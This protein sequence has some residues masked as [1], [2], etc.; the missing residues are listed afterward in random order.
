MHEKRS[1]KDTE[2]LFGKCLKKGLQQNV[3]LRNNSFYVWPNLMH[4]S[5]AEKFI[6]QKCIATTRPGI[7]CG[8][9]NILEHNWNNSLI[10]T[11]GP[12]QITGQ[13]IDRQYSIMNTKGLKLIRITQLLDDFSGSRVLSLLLVV[14]LVVAERCDFPGVLDFAGVLDGVLVGVLD[15]LLGRVRLLL[16]LLLLL[17]S[18]EPVGDVRGWDL[19]LGRRELRGG[20]IRFSLF[21]VFSM[22][23]TPL[24]AELIAESADVSLGAQLFSSPERSESRSAAA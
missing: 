22:L 20:S 3:S 6:L 21:S 16:R 15:L 24:K 12:Y 5:D 14:G 10:K 9:T 4:I 1:Q 2:I 8:L 13:N 11:I 7:R 23:E 19:L 17:L 18:T